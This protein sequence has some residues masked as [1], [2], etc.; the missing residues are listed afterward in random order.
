[1]KS[2]LVLCVP[3]D[4][5]RFRNVVGALNESDIDVYW[6]RTDPASPA[7]QETIDRAAASRAI[8]FA[9]SESA[10]APANAAFIA[11]ATASV[12]S[13]K[14]L[15]VT[16]DSVELPPEMAG[17]TVY[18]LRGWRSRASS[19]FMLDLVAGVK[20]KAAGLDPPT[21]R[22][23]R[24]LLIQRLYIAVPSAIAAIALFAGL[25]RD[26]GADRIA[27]PAEAAAWSALAPGSCD[28]LRAFLGKHGNG[29]H[30]DEA[31]ALLASRKTISRQQSKTVDRPLPLYVSSTG[32]PV[33]GNTGGA[34]T[35][36][37]RLASAE[38]RQ[39][40]R[41][42][43]DA[44]SSR[45]LSSEAEINGFDCH[46]TGSGVVCAAEGQAR[47]RL[48]EQELRTVEICGSTG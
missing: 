35:I 37:R 21:P 38:S 30:A 41:G 27:S 47:C 2:V 44:S 4:Y 20:A 46:N 1:M 9:F 13:G 3:E 45:L 17:C 28:D 11:L 24:Q 6:D 26:L 33:S 19:L 12:R 16:L 14:A 36:A 34:R 18:D 32:A 48:E 40:C 31:Q 43:A 23:A 8:V 29:V 5:V 25:Y 15:C 42:L 22:A 10:L 7:W 39:L